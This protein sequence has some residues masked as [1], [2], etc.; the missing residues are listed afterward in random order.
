MLLTCKKLLKCLHMAVAT[1]WAWAVSRLVLCLLRCPGTESPCLGVFVSPPSFEI[2]TSHPQG[3]WLT[4]FLV[5]LPAK[6]Q[7]QQALKGRPDYKP[8]EVLLYLFC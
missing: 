4:S 2:S 6:F 1:I 7:S 3:N 8:E 5:N